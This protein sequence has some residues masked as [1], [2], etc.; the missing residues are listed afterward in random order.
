MRLQYCTRYGEKLKLFVFFGTVALN[1]I[2]RLLLHDDRC[3]CFI[4]FVCRMKIVSWN[5]KD[6]KQFDSDCLINFIAEQEPDILFLQE[7]KLTESNAKVYT[8]FFS[9]KFQVYHNLLSTFSS[10]IMVLIRKPLTPKVN[11]FEQHAIFKGRVI[12]LEFDEFFVLNTYAVYP[13]GN[14]KAKLQEKL[15][16]RIHEYDKLMLETLDELKRQKPVIWCGDFNVAQ[17][18]D[19]HPTVKYRYPKEIK[20]NLTLMQTDF[21]DLHRALHPQ[22]DGYTFWSDHNPNSRSENI[23]WKLDY[24]MVDNRLSTIPLQNQTKC[25]IL[26]DVVGSDHAPITL[27]LCIEI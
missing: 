24:M 13:G 14:T 15:S 16:I 17:D 20:E 6:L 7:T 19:I 27:T 9:D 10:G 23:G 12:S 21:T 4:V 1:F 5:I 18:K 3:H 25:D 2:L 26:K 11:L 22:D 8:S